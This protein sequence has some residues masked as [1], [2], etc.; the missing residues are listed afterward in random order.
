MSSTPGWMPLAL[1]MLYAFTVVVATASTVRA[2]HAKA[3]SPQARESCRQAVAHWTAAVVVLVMLTVVR[4]RLDG[5]GG[6]G[7]RRDAV[8][9]PWRAIALVGAHV[10]GTAALVVAL[11][12]L[13]WAWRERGKR[14]QR[15][16]HEREAVQGRVQ[17]VVARHDAV[18]AEYGGALVDVLAALQHPAIFDSSFAATKQFE[19]ARID[20]DDARIVLRIDERD[21]HLERY[22]Q[23]VTELEVSW[24]GAQGHA[25]RIGTSYLEAVEAQ[26]LATVVELVAVVQG[27]ASDQEK[28]LAYERIQ[29][30]R[31]LVGT[32]VRIPQQAELAIERLARSVLPR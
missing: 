12:V 1:S 4:T 6:A 17:T 19:R 16:Q 22:H 23:A 30:I 25:R 21:E 14:R 20:A 11:L 2:L 26:R 13:L 7:E 10:I 9:I 3:H 5:C 32:A 15:A 18:L 29:T 31:H 27:S 28:A 8:S 24:R